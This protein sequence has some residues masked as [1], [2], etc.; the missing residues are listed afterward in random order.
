MRP[1]YSSM[2]PAALVIPLDSRHGEMFQLNQTKVLLW[3]RGVRTMTDVLNMRD[4]HQTPRLLR[5]RNRHYSA[6]LVC[7]PL[8]TKPNV[9]Q[10]PDNSVPAAP[11]HSETLNIEYRVRLLIY[12]TS[13]THLGFRNSTRSHWKSL[14]REK[15]RNLF[16][17]LIMGRGSEV[18]REGRQGRTAGGRKNMLIST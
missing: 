7:D 15:D 4:I 14:L 16:P 12:S 8:F 2:E 5:N 11:K 18:E 1:L 6:A 13:L 3:R 9:P 17:T 10:C